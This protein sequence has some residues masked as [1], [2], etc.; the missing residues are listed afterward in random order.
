MV[1]TELP[2][3]LVD[4]N[5]EPDTLIDFPCL[6]HIKA[7]GNAK[8]NFV[9]KIVNVI[10]SMNNEF[11]TKT[12]RTRLSSEENFISVSFDVFVENK[13]ELDSIYQALHKVEGVRYLL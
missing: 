5:L 8:D 11:D 2:N 1:S 3:E 9:E 4:D 12:I 6:F 13:K 10:L 7:V